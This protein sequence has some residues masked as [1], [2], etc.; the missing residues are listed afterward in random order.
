MASV[1]ASLRRLGPAAFVLKAILAAAVADVLLLAFILLRRTYRKRYFA[2]R[3]A[4]VFE[5]QTQ[6]DAS[7]GGQIPYETCERGI[8]T[9][10]LWRPSPWT[11]LK[12]PGREDRR[13]CW[14]FYGQAG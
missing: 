6:W 8:S 3:D 11:G 13:A 1:F 5:L 4:R 10:A 9:V 7:I 2:R 12:W 14:R